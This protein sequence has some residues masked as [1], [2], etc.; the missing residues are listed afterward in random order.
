MVRYLTDERAMDILR[1]EGLTR[2]VKA[3]KLH[4]PNLRH[5]LQR[6]IDRVLDLTFEHIEI[7]RLINLTISDISS[8][9]EVAMKVTYYVL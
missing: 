2:V 4:H 7:A 1:N 3:Y 5:T 8:I 6:L 9:Q